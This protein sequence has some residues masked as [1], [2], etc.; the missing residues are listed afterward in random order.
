MKTNKTRMKATK[1]SLTTTAQQQ[2]EIN[3]DNKTKTN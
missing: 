1:T 3:R 2:H